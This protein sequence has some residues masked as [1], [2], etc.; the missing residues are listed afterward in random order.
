MKYD[1]RAEETAYLAVE[2]LDGALVLPFK[3][4][5]PLDN[6]AGFLIRHLTKCAIHRIVALS[7]WSSRR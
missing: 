2:G 5:N 7:V 6:L 4:E 1:L 3:C